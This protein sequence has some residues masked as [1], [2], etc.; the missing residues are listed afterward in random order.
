MAF[1]KQPEVSTYQNKEIPLIAQSFSRG[2]SPVVDVQYINCFPEYLKSKLTQT[3]DLRLRKRSGSS[4]LA[5]LVTSVTR[6]IYYWEDQ[7][8]LYVAQGSNVYIYNVPTFTLAATLSNVYPTTAS[9]DVGFTEFLYDDGTVKLV[10]TDGTTLS[11]IDSANVVVASADPDLPVP[12][13]PSPLYLDGYLFLLKSGT[14][15]LYN[16]TLND[17]LAYVAGDFISSEMFPDRV[18]KVMKLNN[19]ILVFGSDSVEYYWDAANETGSPLQRNDTPV[20][21]MGLV[22]GIA[23]IGNRIYFVGDSNHSE[24]NVYMLEDFKVNPVG[25]E[26][27]RRFLTARSNYTIFANIVST[28]GHDFYVMYLDGYTYALELE[29]NIWHRWSFGALDYFDIQFTQN[30]RT[31]T[32]YTPVFIR[33]DVG[34]LY[35]FD[36]TVYQDANATITTQWVTDN[37]YFESY[38]NKF[39]STLEVFADKTTGSNPLLIQWSDDDYQTYNTG[40]SLELNQEIPRLH[41]LGR[42]R[43]RAFKFTHTADQP[44]RVQRLSS[45]LNLGIA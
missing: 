16:S 31:G 24:V 7:S 18:T 20:K 15:D 4:E 43:R 1:S 5:N 6:N 42:F 17:P 26:F 40:L 38:N 25:D 3:Q 2:S 14:A 23:Q 11:T 33:L 8:K 27:I 10:T 28:D 44:L 32:S 45:D 22:G 9:G 12:H 13:I 29:T 41:R 34:I 21:L 19:Y 30:C 35:K 39:M 36:S 37:Q